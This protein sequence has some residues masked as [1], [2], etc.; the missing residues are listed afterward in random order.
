MAKPNGLASSG[1]PSVPAFST[2]VVER[3]RSSHRDGVTPIPG[4][5]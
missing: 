1:N 5:H 2:T 3:V 4:P